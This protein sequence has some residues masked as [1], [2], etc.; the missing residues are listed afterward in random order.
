MKKVLAVLVLL[1]SGFAMAHGGGTDKD[2]C[3]VDH[4]T[5]QKHCH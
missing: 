4:K 3:H 5:N 2:G 1:A